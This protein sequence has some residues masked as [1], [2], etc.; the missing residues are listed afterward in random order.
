MKLREL[1]RSR[2]EA[3]PS[4]G[5][6]E[7][8]RKTPPATEELSWKYAQE[9]LDY[10]DY[11]RE[12]LLKL[13]KE[14]QE[15]SA[16]ASSEEIVKLE[17]EKDRRQALLRENLVKVGKNLD[18]GLMARRKLELDREVNQEEDDD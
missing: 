7:H 1:F 3:P 17:Q 5:K 8:S 13:D 15:K 6:I 10:E 11:T 14:F 4:I 9:F 16:G 18:E 12:E 2:V